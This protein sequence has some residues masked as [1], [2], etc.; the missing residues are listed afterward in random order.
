LD[1]AFFARTHPAL[2]IHGEKTQLAVDISRAAFLPAIVAP[3]GFE[4]L[5]S[6]HHRLTQNLTSHET[7]T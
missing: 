7:S 3:R 1:P 4:K 5:Q 6:A 2:H